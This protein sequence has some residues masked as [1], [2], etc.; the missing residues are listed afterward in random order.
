MNISL[1]RFSASSS[2]F[3]LLFSATTA[4][5][6][7]HSARADVKVVSRVTM[8]GLSGQ[9][10][11][12]MPSGPQSQTT[13]YKGAKI[14]TEANDGKQVTIYDA[15]TKTL[16]VLNPTKKTYTTVPVSAMAQD[17]RLAMLDI[18]TTSTVKPGGKTK[19][20]AGKPAKNYVW[21]ATIA[22]GMKQGAMPPGGAS[23][24]A[25]TPSGTLFSITMNGEQWTT[26]AVKM[27]GATGKGML[28]VLSGP[29]AAM[30]GLEPLIA[31]LSTIKGVPLT[32][33]VRQSFA[34]GAGL[35]GSGTALPARTMTTQT[36]VVSIT[37]ANL[38]ATLFAVPAGYTKAAMPRGGGVGPMGM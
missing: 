31:K 6:V 27:P 26:E 24:G 25:Q 11:S 30:P 33:T 13:Y 23:K 4:L 5:G 1:R 20:I 15:Q 10:A 9:M 28:G 32:S 17:P 38:P 29:A 22:M 36:D 12:Q 19:T 21:Q 7:S 34:R 35:S 3:V 8:T 37:E 18:K 2:S 16:T 14:R